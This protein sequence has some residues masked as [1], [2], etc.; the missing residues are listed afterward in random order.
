MRL[1]GTRSC[2][3]QPDW[4]K[5]ALTSQRR[6]SHQRV[7]WL[8]AHRRELK[9]PAR[10]PVH[11][12]RPSA[13]PYTAPRRQPE[14]SGLEPAHAVAG[15]GRA[16]NGG[17]RRCTLRGQHGLSARTEGGLALIRMCHRTISRKPMTR[18]AAGSIRDQSRCAHPHAALSLKGQGSVSEPSFQLNNTC[19][20]PGQALDAPTMPWPG[21]KPNEWSR[22]ESPQPARTISLHEGCQSSFRATFFSSHASSRSPIWK[23]ALPS[24]RTPHS[25]PS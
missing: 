1:D 9:T 16:R 4:T 20:A 22:P 24:R 10:L 21:A 5:P 15:S 7:L 14:T 2:R 8:N 11:V 19:L 25:N 23:S 13:A 6:R 12:R 18:H 17:D 3:P